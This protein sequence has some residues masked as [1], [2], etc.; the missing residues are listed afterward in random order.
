MANW[1]LES[2]KWKLIVNRITPCSFKT[3][4]HSVLMGCSFGF[5]TPNRIGDYAG[6]TIPFGNEIKP[7]IVALNMIN[8]FSQFLA[9]S[10]AGLICLF[11]YSQ[12]ISFFSLPV[13]IAAGMMFILVAA[14]FIGVALYPQHLSAII[15]K[16]G[17][18]NRYITK[19]L[20]LPR[21]P[22]GKLLQ[23]IGISMLRATVF[24]VQLVLVILI[25]SD[26]IHIF[27]TIVACGVYFVVLTVSPSLVFNKLGLR[28]ALSVLILAPVTG[29]PVI[30][31]LSVFVLWF[32]NQVIP[33]LIGSILLIKRSV[34]QP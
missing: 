9:V 4:A 14:F 30:A 21:F 5:I 10:V 29:S 7:N 33:V 20:L 11:F 3:A 15:Q 18:K 6:R 27:Q 32:V 1:W 8:G 19:A 34:Q 22:A 2:V 24:I 31:A 26:E 16:T 13:I 28:E 23:V 25:F 12:H 17:L